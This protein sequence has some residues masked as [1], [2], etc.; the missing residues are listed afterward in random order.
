[1]YIVTGATGQLGRLVVEQLLKVVPASQ[2]VAAVRTPE[3][4]AD[5]IAL[6]VKVR[7]ADYDRP[8]TLDSAFKG[9][10]TLLLISSSEL[11]QRAAQ[12]QAVID[13]AKRVGVQLLA[14]TSVLRADSSPLSVAVE[15]RQTE[16]A[17][18]KSGLPFVL[19]RNG[20]YTENY[21]AGIP[22]ALAHGA[23]FGSAGG[24][25]ISSAPRA[26]YA[27]AAVA[28][29]TAKDNQAGRTYEL[30]GDDS[31]TL[32]EFAAELSK[33]TGQAIGYT[34]LPQADFE[35]AL[36][37]A[38]LPNFVAALLANSDVGASKGALFDEGHQLSSLIGR[39]TVPL[40]QTVAAE[41]KN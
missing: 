20:W 33:Q 34:D 22:G 32:A 35:A 40:A 25:R 17:L 27:A 18:Q 36:V 16:A 30:A 2:I 15:H 24:G 37:Q 14:Y 3:K 9:A 29:L 12:H 10:E 5:L 28:V 31:Y 38:G 41:L 11:G 7:H 4:A 21:T 19:L 13:A 23:V 26:D 1:M 8:E 39:R 6:G